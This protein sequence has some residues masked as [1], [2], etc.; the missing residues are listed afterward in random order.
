MKRFIATSPGFPGEVHLVYH[1]DGRLVLLDMLKAELTPEQIQYLMNRTP[2]TYNPEAF[3]AAFGTAKLEFIQEDYKVSFEG[4]WDRYDQKVNKIRAQKLWDRLSG[5]QQ[6]KAYFG[7]TAY[8]RHLQA[9]P[10]KS[11]AD[12]ETYLRNKYWEN[13]WK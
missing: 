6:I 4:F 11:K 5:V 7:L 1:N 9:N 13:E 10:W 12:P 3:K 2:A 8:F